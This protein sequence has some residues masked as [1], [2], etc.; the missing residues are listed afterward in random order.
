MVEKSVDAIKVYGWMSDYTG[1]GV[2]RISLP[3]G[4]LY[5]NHPDLLVKANSVIED[6]DARTADIIVCQR[7]C[8]DE[9]LKLIKKWKRNYKAK[10]VFETDDDILNIDSSN[11]A[12]KFYSNQ[13]IKDNI[14]EIAEISDLITTS[15]QPLAETL[16]PFNDNITVL[17]N[18]IDEKLFTFDSTPP[19]TNKTII[20]WAG[21]ITHQIDFA[22]CS[23][24]LRR[25]MELQKETWLHLY[26][27]LYNP[28]LNERVYFTPWSDDMESFHKSLR[29]HIGLAPLRECSF[30]ESKSYIKM[31]E[32]AALGIPAIASNVTS[33]N[34]FVQDT[35]TGYLVDNNAEWKHR[36]LNLVRNPDLRSYIGSNAQK[37][38]RDFTIQKNYA[39][40][41]DTYQ[42]L[43]N[44][45]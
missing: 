18:F 40:W 19:D 26:G 35:E 21:S 25:V 8:T 22:V 23:N 45:T 33:Y 17:P 42:E 37:Y 2:Y 4:Q 27:S 13:N 10:I 32:Y 38:A 6:W 20:G 7:S 28:G 39:L 31:L 14:K 30:N 3:F 1:S 11:Q 41:A 29:L 34:S 24:P 36:L 9:Q 12:N 5:S 16:H 43:M 15:T 44:K